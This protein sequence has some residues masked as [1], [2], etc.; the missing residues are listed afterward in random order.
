MHRCSFYSHITA[1]Y[2]SPVGMT[3]EVVRQITNLMAVMLKIPEAYVDFTLPDGQRKHYSFQ[4]DEIV[5]FG[6]PTYAGRVPNKILPLIR[7][8]FSGNGAAVIPVVTF[9]NRSFDDSLSELFSELVSNGFRA[10]SAAALV[11]E[12][13]FSDKIGTG[14]PD[15]KDREE[16]T[17]FA[18]KTAEMLMHSPDEPIR[19]KQLRVPGNHPAGPYYTP[20]GIDGKPAK[21]LKAKPITDPE[22]CDHCG[23]C[24][25]TCPMG[26]I[27]QE[28]ETLVAGI[29]IKCQACIK[30]CPKHAKRFADEAFLS[31]VTM[32]E[33][34]YSRRAENVFCISNSKML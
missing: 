8:Q 23:I 29:C 17:A 20:L 12:H 26:S 25:E 30:K 31:H 4:E 27:N 11:T 14:R 28:D 22:I 18:E 33:Q 3:G 2:F 19:Q 32:L 15:T 10:V 7:S 16:I 34:N 1:V 6:V 9:G 24:A 5:V 21:F 13:V